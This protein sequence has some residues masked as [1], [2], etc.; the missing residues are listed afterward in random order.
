MATE[1]ANIRMRQELELETEEAWVVWSH[2]RSQ[3]SFRPGRR[4]GRQG[5]EQRDR[6]HFGGEQRDH[7]H[8]RGEQQDHRHE[9]IG[10]E[11]SFTT[12]R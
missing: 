9:A 1:G 7:R 8:F 2:A 11:I 3:S 6:R 5:G 10:S 12:L 4:V